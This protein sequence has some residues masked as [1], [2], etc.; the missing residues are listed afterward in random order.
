MS[1]G[2]M[3]I[4]FEHCSA[5]PPLRVQV[6]SRSSSPASSAPHTPSDRPTEDAASE[7]AWNLI[8]YDVTWG[9]AYYRY[10]EGTLPG[11]DGLCL[12]LRS[13]TPFRLRRTQKACDKCR[14][15][16]AKCSGDRPT[17]GR[18]A[19]RGYTCEYAPEER[20]PTAS[21]ARA[22]RRHA[23]YTKREP[24]EDASDDAECSSSAESDASSSPGF[25][26]LYS[27]LSVKEEPREA[28]SPE[29]AFA[30]YADSMSDTASSAAAEYYSP[31]EDATAA[32]HAYG[33][34]ATS[35]GEP[36]YYGAQQLPSPS[37]FAQ[38][39]PPHAHPHAVHAP[40]PVRCTGSPPF[41]AHEGA[42]RLDAHGFAQDGMLLDFATC[43]PPIAL[44]QLPPM[45]PVSAAAF[46]YGQPQPVYYEAHASLYPTYLQYAYDAPAYVPGQQEGA[47]GA[48]MYMVPVGA[49][50]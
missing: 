2:R 28:A 9:M 20:H 7:D 6:S 4:T 15:R 13:P 46:Q 37:Y 10:R 17:C 39:L 47:E 29:L 45:A 31:W 33:S 44:P 8:P 40:R 1:E 43:A 36:E 26:Q 22:H 3:T 27:R 16:K 30:D 34:P 24:S 42:P 32:H 21:S 25:A 5:R 48:M 12:F 19:A 23:P 35:F 49:A 38:E 50:M 18:C 11:P 41:L 14:H